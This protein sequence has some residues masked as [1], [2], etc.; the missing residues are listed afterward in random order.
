MFGWLT[1]K[2]VWAFLSGIS[3][4]AWLIAGAVALWGWW[5]VHQYNAG[6]NAKELEVKIAT[7]EKNAEVQ[8]K[9]DEEEARANR[10]LN[11]ENK[12]LQKAV[13]D[14]IEKLK[15]RGVPCTLGDDADDLN[16]L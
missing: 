11:E 5:S 2:L 8:K 16:R 3:L 15:K 6:W 12:Q 9:A 13:N 10:E 14:Y 1:W 4:R 7:L